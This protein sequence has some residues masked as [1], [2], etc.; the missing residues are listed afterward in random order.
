MRKSS[1]PVQRKSSARKFRAEILRRK[2][3]DG[4]AP[5]AV[6]PAQRIDQL[7]PVFG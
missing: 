1:T 4:I 5:L 2:S 7:S 6:L 3:S